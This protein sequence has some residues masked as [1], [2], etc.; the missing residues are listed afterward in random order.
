MNELELNQ[1]YV[2]AFDHL[3]QLISDTD[4]AISR[5]QR[6]DDKLGVRQYE[7]LKKDYVQQLAELISK[8]P[9]SITV[10]AVM[11]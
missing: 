6:T 10:Q 1:N 8:T 11:H 3:L 5:S 7:Y 4:E 9:K 2:K